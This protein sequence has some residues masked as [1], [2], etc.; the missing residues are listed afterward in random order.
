M[1]KKWLAPAIALG[2]LAFALAV[3][4]SLP[5]RIPTHWNFSGE[6]DAYSA[7]WPGAFLLPAMALGVWLLL[8]GLR[9]IDPRKEHYEKFEDTYWLVINLLALFF[10]VME[11]VTLG[12]ALGWP[13]DMTRAMLAI[14]GL[15]F[16][17]LGNYLPRLKSNW[18]MGVRTPWTLESDVVWR[19][20]HR[21]AGRTFVIGGLLCLLA[22]LLPFPAAPAV[23]IGGLVLAGMIPVVYS[24]FAWREERATREA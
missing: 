2:M 22:A 4:P 15:M 21:L 8:L 1:K 9:R 5:D 7:K 20:T 19:K 11:V 13:V 3:F 14:L 18:W 10:A 24:Y 16:A 23:A 6:V 17:G 12:A